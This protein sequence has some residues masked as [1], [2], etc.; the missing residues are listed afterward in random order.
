[1]AI[2]HLRAWRRPSRRR[3]QG[4]H[5]ASLVEFALVLP[6]FAILLFGLIDF[7]LVFGSFVTLRNG[8]ATATREGTVNET[9]SFTGTC[10][11]SSASVTTVTADLVCTII[12]R[13]GALPSL[14]STGIAV[15]I[16]FPTTSSGTTPVQG[17]DLEVCVQGTM[18]SVTGLM[19]FVLNG[20][21][22]TSSST[23][24]LEKTPEFSSFTASDGSVSLTN[25]SQ[26]TTVTGRG[27]GTG[28]G[29]TC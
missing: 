28:I 4:E 22:M 24:Q 17:Q 23:I 25:G 5:G 8:V 14:T 13:I 15:G 16:A 12:A 2:R 10:S 20:R 27:T 1:M 26:T 3:L 7:G 9:Q 6:V 29:T 18:K 21:H 11:K 19:G